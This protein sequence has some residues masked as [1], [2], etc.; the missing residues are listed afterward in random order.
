MAAKIATAP[1]DGRI[2]WATLTSASQARIG[3]AALEKAVAQ[4]IFE[5]DYGKGPAGRA[6]EAALEIADLELQ[7]VAIGQ[8]DERL[9]V[10][11]EF[12]ETAY[13][14]P[15]ALGL[16]CHGCGCSEH[17]ACE[18]SCGWVS[19]TRCT[20]CHEDGRATA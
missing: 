19:E 7:L 1:F 15:S 2:A 12:R 6:A 17:D 8:M 3:A 13:R 5:R 11:A 14:I 18:P 10:E 4:A 16:V 9:W 20:A